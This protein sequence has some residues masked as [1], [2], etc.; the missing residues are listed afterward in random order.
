MSKGYFTLSDGSHG[1]KE[2]RIFAVTVATN[3]K[4][5]SQWIQFVDTCWYVE[6]RLNIPELRKEVF[7]GVKGCSQ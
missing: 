3:E 2:S 5:T 6:E 1:Y 7:S 4:N